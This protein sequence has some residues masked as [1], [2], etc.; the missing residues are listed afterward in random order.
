MRI[1]LLAFLISLAF[2]MS[3]V[4]MTHVVD[5]GG[6]GDYTSIQ[7]AIDAAADGDTILVRAGTYN[8]PENRDLSF[9]GKDLVLRADN[10]SENSI[11]DCEGLGR[12]IFLNGGQDRSTIIEGLVFKNGWHTSSGGACYFYGA[13]PSVRYC[14][15]ESNGSV[16]GGAIY[17]LGAGAAGM[18]LENCSFIYNIG[19]YGG[20]LFATGLLAPDIYGCEFKYNDGDLK[21]G[22]IHT[23]QSSGTIDNCFFK[24]NSSL[25]GGAVSLYNSSS[26]LI[27]NCLFEDNDAEDGGGV[28]TF[29]CCAP[30]IRSCTFV[31]NSAGEGGS[32]HFDFLSNALV[33]QCILAF[34]TTGNVMYC[35]TSTPEIYHNLIWSNGGGDI[36]CGDTHDNIYANPEFCGVTN[37]GPYTLQS[38]SPAA[39]ANNAFDVV[40]GAFPVDCDET[41]AKTS[42][43]SRLKASF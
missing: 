34:G 1:S 40:M 31:H 23:V 25:T 21:G 42:S 41:S 4:A 36:I 3:A 6:G 19:D 15:F 13:S 33:Y 20:A 24:G 5:I 9:S 30:E 12:A 38:D 37:N 16:Q 7:P 2:A 35:G 29:N 10:F 8:G 18:L 11:I 28:A 26:P 22:A 43:W 14:L 27:E 17:V 32:L 39:A